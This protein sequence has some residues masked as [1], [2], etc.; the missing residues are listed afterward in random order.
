VHFLN[1]GAQLKLQRCAFQIWVETDKNHLAAM[2]HHDDVVPGFLIL[3]IVA[4]MRK[5]ITLDCQQ[6]DIDVLSTVYPSAHCAHTVTGLEPLVV[7]KACEVLVD[8]LA[9]RELFRFFVI[10][11]AALVIGP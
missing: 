11:L 9:D 7:S 1:Q 4:P 3:L 6:R 5:L 10:Q 2:F 8:R